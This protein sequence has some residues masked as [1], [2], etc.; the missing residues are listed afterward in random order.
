MARTFVVTAREIC[1]K[2][3]GTGYVYHPR[4]EQYWLENDG[5]RM[6]AQDDVDWFRAQGF[7]VSSP[8]DLP[9]EEIVC[10]KCTGNKVLITRGIPLEEALKELGVEVSDVC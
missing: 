7:D 3:G 1:N 10:P 9:P 2:C 5:R 4:W 8:R 6:L